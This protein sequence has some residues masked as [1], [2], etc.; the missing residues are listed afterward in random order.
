MNLAFNVTD[1]YVDYMSVTLLSIL[2][3]TNSKVDAYIL[4]SYFSEYSRLKLEKLQLAYPNL[5]CHIIDVNVEMF[6]NLPLNRDHIQSFEAYFRLAF[7]TLLPDTV[8]KILYLDCDLLIQNDLQPLW[9]TDF[10]GYYMAGV[11]EP[12]SQGAHEYRQKIGM[13]D[14][15][16][17]VNS[18]VLLIDLKKMRSD[19]IQDS[20]FICANEIKDKILL[21]DQ[22][23]IN[24]SLEGQIFPLPQTYNFMHMYKEDVI[25]D[26]QM[27]II[28]FALTK[29]WDKKADVN[30]YKRRSIDAYN[31]M[32]K[33]YRQLIEPLI[34]V[35]VS[36]NSSENLDDLLS[37][38]QN[39]TYQNTD[40]LLLDSIQS[41]ETFDSCHTFCKS[42]YRMRYYR[43]SDSNKVVSTGLDKML[44]EYVFFIDTNSQLTTETLAQLFAKMVRQQ[45]SFCGITNE[46]NEC[47]Q[48]AQF[49]NALD[50]HLPLKNNVLNGCL[51][52]DTILT[53]LKQCLVECHDSIASRLVMLS[54]HPVTTLMCENVVLNNKPVS[55]DNVLPN[56]TEQLHVYYRFLMKYANN[57][58]THFI[59]FCI[60]TLQS[61]LDKSSNDFEVMNLKQDVSCLQ[62]SRYLFEQKNKV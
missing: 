54:D 40:I 60:N 33:A 8:E 19:N 34:T 13:K 47:V 35:V 51:M 7:P 38:L 43:M 62:I 53:S 50:S 58:N 4:T 36:V 45:V 30:E 27:T 14:T 10:S 49:L 46:Q 59:D 23:I 5:T 26:S 1:N 6:A 39:Q 28:H 37:K 25:D 17:Y 21:Q 52:R 20:I 15:T 9:D 24:V 42:D 41:K 11:R 48:S 31:D 3:H 22:D 2:K 12:F 18:G 61:M 56:L 57:V 29:P 16:G 32:S 44:G 55:L